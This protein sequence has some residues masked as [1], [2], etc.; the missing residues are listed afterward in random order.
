MTVYIGDLYKLATPQPI[1]EAAS[2]EMD[3]QATIIGTRASFYFGIM[4]LIAN[5][6]MPSFTKEESPGGG[7]D[8]SFLTEKLPWLAK[9]QVFHIC[10]LWAFGHL[11]FAACMTATL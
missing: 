3:K 5:F 9:L 2:D 4:S 8:P 1:D 10:E 7:E 6:V 11:L